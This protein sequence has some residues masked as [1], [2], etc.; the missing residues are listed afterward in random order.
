MNHVDDLMNAA[1]I[2]VTLPFQSPRGPTAL[3]RLQ[4]DVVLSPYQTKI[5]NSS[6]VGLL[7]NQSGGS[8][9]SRKN[10]IKREANTLK[11]YLPR[12]LDTDLIE[13]ITR[14]SKV[15]F[16]HVIFFLMNIIAK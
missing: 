11:E 10:I 3:R 7:P 15:M 9:E 2:P 14:L 13:A 16:M 4:D 5:D 8:V 6:S 12:L 1:P